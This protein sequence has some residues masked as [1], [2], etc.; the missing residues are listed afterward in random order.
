M[1]TDLPPIAGPVLINGV[2][3]PANPTTV[4]PAFPPALTVVLD[5]TNTALVGLASSGAGGS[6]FRGLVIQRF[7][8]SGILLNDDFGGDRVQ[9]SFIGTNASGSTAAGNAN[10]GVTVG[11]K[12]FNTPSFIGTDGDEINDANEGNVISGNG[13]HGVRLQNALAVKV[14]GNRIGT[15]PAGT[16][17]LPNNG[18]GVRVTVGSTNNVIGTDG[19]GKSDDV[20]GN[21][22]S[23][24]TD[25]GVVVFGDSS[26]GHRV[27]GNRIGT[28]AAGTAALGNQGGVRVDGGTLNNVIEGNLVSGNG[29]LGGVSVAE[30]GTNANRVRNNEIGTDINGGPLGNAGNGVEIDTGPHDARIED[31]RIANNGGAGIALIDDATAFQLLSPFR[32]NSISDNGALGIDLRPAGA[33]GVTANDAFDLDIGPNRGQNF[34]VL[35]SASLA[36]ADTSV[37]GTLNSTPGATFTIELFANDSCDAS[38]NGEGETFL[39]SLVTGTTDGSGN[40]ELLHFRDRALGR[41]VPHGHRD[42]RGWR[43]LRVLRVHRGGGATPHG[44]SHRDRDAHHDARAADADTHRDT[45]AADTDTH[46]DTGPAD[47]HADGDAGAADTH[48][49][50]DAGPADTHTYRHARAAD[51]DRNADPDAH[52]DADPHRDTDENAD[53]HANT[54]CNRDDHP[55]PDGDRNPDAD[56]HSDR[57]TDGDPD[58]R[59]ARP[60]SLQVLPGRQPHAVGG[61]DGHAIRSVRQQADDGAEA[62]PPLHRRR[63]ERRGCPRS[64]PEPRVLRP[65]GSERRAVH[66]AHRRGRQSVRNEHLERGGSA[67]TLRADGARRRADAVLARSLPVLRREDPARR[68]RLR[69]ADGD[70]RGSLRE[71]DDDRLQ[72]EAPL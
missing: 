31:N 45:R 51:T 54:G 61:P 18:Q 46:R 34:P 48:A 37:Q 2:G 5:G 8:Q 52:G 58:A 38:G 41:R 36:G 47:A 72:A 55:D 30:E 3:T 43:N 33:S 39:T 17:A 14:A 63:Q 66:T 1:A 29:A 25:Y 23:G 69:A 28:N 67:R 56:R 7:T 53:R 15:N 12:P 64:H 24:N 65:Q 40:V 22:I 6:T 13:A 62:E 57:D 27:A 21:L 11:G 59:A 10:G 19:D 20:E 70:G 26:I 16:A 32:R 60:R 68:A 9:C 71:Q 50:R 4:C 35:T 44:D 42:E 49:H